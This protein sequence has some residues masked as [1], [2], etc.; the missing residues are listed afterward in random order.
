MEEIDIFPGP[1]DSIPSSIENDDFD[2]ENDDNSTYL[3][4]FESFHVNY[5]NSRDSTIDNREDIPVENSDSFLEKVETTPE[6]ETFK[7]DSKEKNSSHNDLGSNLDDF[8]NCDDSR[9][10]GLVLHSLELHILSFILGIPI[11]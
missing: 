4:E 6:L 3:F 11:S 1:D 8:R 2:S 7:F 9:A 5:P 10:R